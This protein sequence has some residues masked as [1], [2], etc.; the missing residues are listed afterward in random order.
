MQLYLKPPRG[1]KPMYDKGLVKL[2]LELHIE[3]S[4][5]YR[6][7]FKLRQIDTPSMQQLWDIY[8]SRPRK[9]SREVGLMRRMKGFGNF[10]EFYAGVE[11]NESWEKDFRPI[12]E[13]RY[14]EMLMPV[15]LVMMLD[16]YFR[17]MP[18]TMVA[19]TPEIIELGKK[20]GCPAALIAEVMALFCHCDPLFSKE[21][22]PSHPLLEACREIWQ[23][24]GN[25]TPEALS[26][27]A[28]QLRS[29]W[30]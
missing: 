5:L 30:K 21:S 14:G 24:Y 18:D 28:A 11:V 15:S 4:Y 9:L 20:I 19:D 26:A 17:L 27:L 10:E 1:L 8:G 29:Y 13:Q 3:P 25:E 7:M 12:D 23:R 16:L 22:E 6:R 2:A